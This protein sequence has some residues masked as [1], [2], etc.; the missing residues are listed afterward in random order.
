MNAKNCPCLVIAPAAVLLTARFVA[1]GALL[2]AAFGKLRHPDVFMLAISSFELL[3]DALVP[4]FA[5][6]VPWV[7]T[8]AG[9]A[10]V[11]GFWTRGAGLVATG[12]YTMFTAAVVSVLARNMDV[13]CGCFG[14]IMG[15]GEVGANTVVRNLVFVVAAALPW[16]LG[17]GSASLDAVLDRSR[18]GGEQAGCGCSKAAGIAEESAT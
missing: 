17:G 10:L 5:Y 4:Y 6:A 18:A 3:P 14:G 13:D 11:Y 12:L 15:S 2:I 8:L 9:L 7:E 16:W 1:G